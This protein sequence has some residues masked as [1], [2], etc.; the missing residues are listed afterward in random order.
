MQEDKT[1]FFIHK[2]EKFD[3]EPPINLLPQRI[4]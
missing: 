4:D 2:E 1:N 3:Y